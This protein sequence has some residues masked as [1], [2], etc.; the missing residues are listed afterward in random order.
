MPSPEGEARADARV[1]QPELDGF[2][3]APAASVLRDVVVERMA[4]IAA[5]IRMRTYEKAMIVDRIH[6]FHD[7]SLGTHHR[8]SST[9][10][11]WSPFSAGAGLSAITTSASAFAKSVCPTSSRTASANRIRPESS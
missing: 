3:E 5:G 7:S 8:T 4:A 10:H 2:R 11:V 1:G 9:V 6:R